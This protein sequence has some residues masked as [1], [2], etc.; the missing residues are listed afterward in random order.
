MIIHRFRNRAFRA[1]NSRCS[2]I[3]P[4]PARTVL[5]PRIR[6]SGPRVPLRVPNLC[7]LC[8]S[9]NRCRCCVPCR[10]GRVRSSESVIGVAV[11]GKHYNRLLD[12]AVVGFWC[13]CAGV[14]SAGATPVAVITVVVRVHRSLHN[15][16]VV[17]AVEVSQINLIISW[18]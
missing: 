13:G 18:G 1:R 7:P 11:L 2:C 14:S 16:V 5:L 17:V 3:R 10:S 6:S 8:R 4:L 12:V 15:R 9:R